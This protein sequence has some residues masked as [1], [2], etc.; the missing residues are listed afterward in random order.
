VEGVEKALDATNHLA[1]PALANVPPLRL[2]SLPAPAFDVVTRRTEL[3][4]LYQFL[5]RRVKNEK[6]GEKN[7]NG[8][9]R[10]FKGG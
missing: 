9:V 6:I 8:R 10:G 3:R 2:R 5:M 1:L 7:G 4:D